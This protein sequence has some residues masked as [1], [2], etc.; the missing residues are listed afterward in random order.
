MSKELLLFLID[1]YNFGIE[2]EMI[3]HVEKIN[4]LNQF[5]V[6][7]DAMV[8]INHNTYNFINFKKFFFHINKIDGNEYLI[9]LKN[10][11]VFNCDKVL[12]YIEKDIEEINTFIIFEEERYKDFFKGIVI[13]NNQ[14]HLV[15]KNLNTDE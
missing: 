6:I 14:P 10:N 8:M 9:I 12:H 13:D 4:L 5:K 15:F 2:S 11:I 7:G 1:K 3:E